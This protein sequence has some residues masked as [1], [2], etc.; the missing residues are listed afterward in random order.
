MTGRISKLGNA[1]SAYKRIGYA[2]VSF[3]WLYLANEERRA[4]LIY[5]VRWTQRRLLAFKYLCIE[6]LQI[7]L[8]HLAS[9]MSLISVVGLVQGLQSFDYYYGMAKPC[10]FF[11]ITSVRNNV[12]RFRRTKVF[13]PYSPFIVEVNRLEITAVRL[14]TKTDN[15]IA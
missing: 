15:Q 11:L 6:L 9:N 8:L 14:M 2:S 5:C 13:Y 12:P 7:F 10:G 4:P 1:L 3:V